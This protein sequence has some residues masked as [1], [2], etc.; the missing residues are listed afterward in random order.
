MSQSSSKNPTEAIWKP[1]SP[2]SKNPATPV[3]K[4][5]MRWYSKMSKRERLTQLYYQAVTAVQAESIIHQSIQCTEMELI[6]C[7]KSIAFDDFQ[8]LYCF[9]VGK[10]GLG[11]AQ[12]CEAILG[13]RIHNGVAISHQE[14]ELHRMTHH[15]STHPLLSEKSIESGEKLIA[16]MEQMNDDDFFIFCLSGGAS[17]MIEKPIEGLSLEDFQKVSQALLGSGIDIKA[18]N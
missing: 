17:A 15:T 16:M 1:T 8:N 7:G 9:T 6:L 3:A 10:A 14:G 12:A 2:K 4:V 18:L 11:M 5:G 13:D